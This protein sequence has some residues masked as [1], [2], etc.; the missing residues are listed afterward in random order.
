MALSEIIDVVSVTGLLGVARISG[1]PQLEQKREVSGLG[2]LH[3]EQKTLAIA[4]LDL[5][6]ST[7]ESSGSSIASGTV[8]EGTELRCRGS[9]RRANSQPRPRLS[10]AMRAPLACT[11]RPARFATFPPHS[12]FTSASTRCEPHDARPPLHREF[13][14]TA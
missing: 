2:R 9:T 4:P 5:P 3:R 13:R 1:A 12:R 14:T 7:M 8:A 11:P 10:T 6:S